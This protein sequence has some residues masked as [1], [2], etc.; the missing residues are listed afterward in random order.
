M[1]E[2]SSRT[3]EEL[4][5]K[6]KGGEMRA[7]EA[8][9]EKYK[10]HAY[11]IAYGFA[12]DREAALDLS[13]EAFVRAYKAINRYK[14][15]FRFFTWFYKI[16]SNLCI[17]HLEKRRVR[18]RYQVSLEEIPF[19]FASSR[20]DPAAAYEQKELRKKLWEGIKNLPPDFKEIIILKHF[21]DFSYKEI[22]EVLQIPIGTVM[23][24]L[25]YARMKLKE[26]L[27]DLI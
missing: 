4:A 15:D 6:A 25:Y 18:K 17:S 7:F 26:E 5:L 24:R 1:S 20:S 14:P 13:Q 8:L 12:G 22:S 10:R 23:S 27:K 2:A 9:V 19:E 3:D 21:R 11:F 16:L